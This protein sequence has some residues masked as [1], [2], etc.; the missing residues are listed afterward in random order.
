MENEKNP[1]GQEV[2]IETGTPLPPPTD[3]IPAEVSPD[4]LN[5]KIQ[6]LSKK[7]TDVSTE[8]ATLKQR[9]SEI[10]GDTENEAVNLS[11]SIPDDSNEIESIA[12]LSETNPREAIRKMGELQ[13]KNLQ[14]FQVITQK[15]KVQEDKFVVYVNDVYSKN[16]DLKVY[17]EFLGASAKQLIAQGVSPYKAVDTVIAEFR[18]RQQMANPPDAS[19]KVKI[20][21]GAR[22]EMPNNPPPP[23]PL[24]LEPD[25]TT[26]DVVNAREELR[27]KRMM[28]ATK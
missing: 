17:D 28:K 2:D 27:I 16:P 22:G 1:E 4:V 5:N 26:T 6:E 10:E 20:P 15:Q 9:I 13:K 11:P 24:P 19:V 21:A 23:K 25:E 3:Q 14:Q 12:E 8:N 7:V 18:K